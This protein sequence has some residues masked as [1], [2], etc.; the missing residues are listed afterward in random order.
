MDLLSRYRGC[1]LGL[2]VGDALGTTLEFSL[3]GTFTPNSDTT[4]AVYGQLAGAFY[5]EDNIPAAWRDTIAQREFIGELAEKL[6][7]AAETSEV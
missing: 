3:P 2:A 5:G 1:L 4:G 7:A 6:Y